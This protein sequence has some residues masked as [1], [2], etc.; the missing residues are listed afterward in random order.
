MLI[1]SIWSIAHA[2]ELEQS[3]QGEKSAYQT[4]FIPLHDLS[5]HHAIPSELLAEDMEE[6]DASNEADTSTLYSIAQELSHI[7]SKQHAAYR[8]L[9]TTVLQEYLTAY[10]RK[11]GLSEFYSLNPVNEIDSYS[12]EL[13]DYG[14]ARCQRIKKTHI[15]IR[16]N[17]PEIPYQLLVPLLDL[18]KRSDLRVRAPH[19][20]PEL[21]GDISTI[22][23]DITEFTSARRKIFKQTRKRAY[24]WGTG[25]CL[26]GTTSYLFYHNTYNSSPFSDFI[27]QSLINTAL[28]SA[29]FLSLRYLSNRTIGSRIRD[30]Q[31]HID[32][33]ITKC[34][35][36]IFNLEPVVICLAR[37]YVHY[38][39]KKEITYIKRRELSGWLCC[40][41]VF[42]RLLDCFKRSRDNGRLLPQRIHHLLGSYY[43]KLSNQIV[44]HNREKTYY[45]CLIEAACRIFTEY[46]TMLMS[47][48]ELQETNIQT[49]LEQSN[50]GNFTGRQIDSLTSSINA[51]KKTL[52]ACM[53]IDVKTHAEKYCRV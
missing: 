22:I 44:E 6:D 12:V 52:E 16:K 19:S 8:K 1:S 48:Y 2:G 5:E 25:I 4:N 32:N 15:R 41:P 38:R 17:D 9:Y 10:P 42:G 28:H 43:T 33:R 47:M 40:R 26:L 37:N 35:P 11:E 18:N 20:L 34:S 46:N 49:V 30:D 24:T 51:T 31:Q 50:F 29:A 45:T 27:N 23:A 13:H 14:N 21:H 53:P 7:R 36:V 3:D 39:L